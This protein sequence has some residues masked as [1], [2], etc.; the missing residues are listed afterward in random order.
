MPESFEDAVKKERLAMMALAESKRKIS[1]FHAQTNTA[2]SIM[3]QGGP[4]QRDAGILPPAGMKL[5]EK[6]EGAD[7]AVD[8]ETGEG[9]YASGK[10]GGNILV[11]DGMYKR[12]SK[13]AMAFPGGV[14]PSVKTTRPW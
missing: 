11:H 4:S 2:R 7:K 3:S 9:F 8:H 6:R 12:Q 14:H 13:P 1:S 5:G 10:G